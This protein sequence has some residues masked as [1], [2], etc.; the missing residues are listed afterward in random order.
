MLK[1]AEMASVTVI[2]SSDVGGENGDRHRFPD[3]GK[4]AASPHFQAEALAGLCAARGPAVILTPDLYHVAEDSPLWEEL[5]ALKGPIV[6]FSGLHPR[7]AEW[8]LR[9]HGVGE[10]GL[11]A[12]NLGIPVQD[13]RLA[14]GTWQGIYLWEHRLQPHRRRVILHFIGE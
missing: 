14:L 8:L 12:V 10:G 1:R 11:T 4:S 13:G 2:V 6:L 9:K 3:G 7:P 5:R